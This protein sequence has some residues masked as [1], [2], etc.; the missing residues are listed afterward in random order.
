MAQIKARLSCCLA[1]SNTSEGNAFDQ[2]SN[3]L[4]STRTASG[5]IRNGSAPPTTSSHTSAATGI[6]SGRA[7]A[8][9]SKLSLG[10]SGRKASR[11]GPDGDYAASGPISDPMAQEFSLDLDLDHM[12]GIVDLR[13]V[14]AQSNG[15]QGPRGQSTSSSGSGGE[16]RK[17]GS[18]TTAGPTGSSASTSSQ[19]NDLLNTRRVTHTADNIP[20]NPFTRQNPFSTS[21]DR[22][23][24][25][26]SRQL[27][28]VTP[29]SPH[30]RFGKSQLPPTVGH[31]RRPSQ[32]RKSSAFVGDEEYADRISQEPVERSRGA[33]QAGMFRDPFTQEAAGVPT[34]AASASNSL[35]PLDYD[36]EPNGALPS[37][38][39]GPFSPGSQV[40]DRPI[41]DT[42]GPEGDPNGAAW[43]APESWGVEV[44]E[45]PAEPHSSDDDDGIGTLLEERKPSED[46]PASP[47]TPRGSGPPPFGAR[48]SNARKAKPRPGTGRSSTARPGTATRAGVRPSTAG[49]TQASGQPVSFRP[50]RVELRGTS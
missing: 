28:S 38:T 21:L 13:A 23:D 36:V 30:S 49:S 37:M 41:L 15:Q 6:E 4:S 9:S 8:S 47:T 48:A 19:P 24:G 11:R 43:T 33:I 17:G 34:S 29:P 35:A 39:D 44:D 32:L 3:T 40:P 1:E 22:G 16:S 20:H 12:E 50:L 42:Q 25:K 10:K 26:G 31:P 27:T 7:D 2:R 18:T 5:A 46:G 14:Q 45:L